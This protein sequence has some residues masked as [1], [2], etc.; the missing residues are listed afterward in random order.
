M[1]ESKPNIC[2]MCHRAESSEVLG[3]F[4]DA[5]SGNGMR[6]QHFWVCNDCAIPLGPD[7]GGVF[8]REE[9]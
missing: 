1:A 5:V 9:N 4:Y 3:N 6:L 8:S 2:V 7:Q